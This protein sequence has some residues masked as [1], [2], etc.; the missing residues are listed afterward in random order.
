MYLSLCC[1]FIKSGKLYRIYDWYDK[2]VAEVSIDEVISMYKKIEKNASLVE[3]IFILY[4]YI[5]MI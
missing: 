1:H 2:K 5:N 4:N 3:T